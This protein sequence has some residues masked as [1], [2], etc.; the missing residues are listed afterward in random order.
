M[1]I[2]K[3][4]NPYIEEEKKERT[5]VENFLFNLLPTNI[6]W[7]FYQVSFCFQYV[8]YFNN[9]LFIRSFAYL[10][11]FTFTF[12]CIYSLQKYFI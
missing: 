9:V 3:T 10:V 1:Y 6:T 12:I 8:Q 11:H 7:F 4:C 2:I 5:Q